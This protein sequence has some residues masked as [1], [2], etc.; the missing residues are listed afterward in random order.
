MATLTVTARGQVK[1]LFPLRLDRCVC[2]GN[3]GGSSKHINVG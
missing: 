3:S 1:G 2:R